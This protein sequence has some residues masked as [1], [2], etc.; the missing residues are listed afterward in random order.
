MANPPTTDPRTPVLIGV[1]I[2]SQR[3]DDPVSAREPIDLMID[4]A[5][6]SGIDAAPTADADVLGNVQ[7]VLVPIGRWAYTNPGRMIADA[8][9]A[10]D[11]TTVSAFPGVSQQT[12]L[13]DACNAIADGTID[14]A[15]VVGGEA[16]HRLLRARI[17]DAD[18]VDTPNTDVADVVLE[19]TGSII[20]THEIEG[21][22]GVMPV[23]YY[24][25]IDSAWRHHRGRTVDEHL[26]ITSRRYE[27]YSEIA[28]ANPH[29]WDDTARSADEIRSA[30]MLA[31]P[32][33]KHHVSNWSVDQA[34]ALLLVSTARAEELGIPRDAWVFPQ[35]FVESNL[36]VDV[37]ARADIHRCVGVELAA[38]AVL[39]A[40][41]CEP[42]DIEFAEFYTCFPIAV[43]IFTDALGMAGRRDTSFTGAMPFAGGPFNNFALHSTAQLAEHLR[44]NPGT[45]GL[46]TTVSGVLTKYGLSIWGTEPNP[47][48]YRFVDVTDAARA[49]TE[50]RE[51]DPTYEGPA[52]I[53]A[54]TV[55]FDRSGPTNAI[56]IVDSP[57]GTR[58]VATSSDPQAMDAMQRIDVCG[59]AVIVAGDEFSL[60]ERF[61]PLR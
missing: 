56:V 50:T 46:V 27:R 25:L 39:E 22:L 40:A 43:D 42:D 20:A 16:G 49:S 21:G 2:V 15:L 47:N 32:Y 52:T 44:A 61:E 26:T 10:H 19:P 54:Y 6:Q 12:L 53:A 34:T 37:S 51:I 31:F 38:D 8:I 13:S 60:A 5:R 33:T 11:A 17:G 35:A 55:L 24:A 57:T 18:V 1:G 58:R 59:E 14:T 7:R 23:G 9:G 30:R 41:G 45:R 3:D 4:A 48:G 29:G 28:A 36:A